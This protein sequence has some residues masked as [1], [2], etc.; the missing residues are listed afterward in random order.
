[1]TW[2]LNIG[3]GLIKSYDIDFQGYGGM[4]IVIIYP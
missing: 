3:N 1:V 4:G 2:F